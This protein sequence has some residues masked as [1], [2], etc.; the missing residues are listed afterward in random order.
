MTQLDQQFR[1]TRPVP[2]NPRCNVC[3]IDFLVEEV[4]YINMGDGYKEQAVRERD[5]FC[6]LC[7]NRKIQES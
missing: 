5:P 7:E 3:N 4:L 1:S 6:Q 2:G